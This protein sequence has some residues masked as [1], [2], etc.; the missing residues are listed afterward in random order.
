MY[1]FLLY[2]SIL[3]VAVVC[4][5]RPLFYSQPPLSCMYSLALS[6]HSPTD[7]LLGLETCF[8]LLY[9]IS[10]FIFSVWTKHPN[11]FLFSHTPCPEVPMSPIS[12]TFNALTLLFYHSTCPSLVNI[13]I[14]PKQNLS[15]AELTW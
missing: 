12:H 5:S 7:L 6:F 11:I 3:V 10:V 13:L 2:L 1:S 15:I 9:T 8:S 4:R 14:L